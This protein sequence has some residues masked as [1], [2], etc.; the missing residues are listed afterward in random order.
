[1]AND[2]YIPEWDEYGDMED[3]HGDDEQEYEEENYTE[4][5]LEGEF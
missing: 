3:Y 4:Y 5:D 1:M 2:Y